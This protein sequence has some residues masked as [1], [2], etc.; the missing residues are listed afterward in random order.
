M[1]KQRKILIVDDDTTL[2]GALAENFKMKGADVYVANEAKTGLQ[3]M[4]KE[5]PDVAIVDIMMPFESG[6]DFVGDIRHLPALEKTFC[7]ILT[8]SLNAEH[9]AEAMDKNVPVFLQ[10]SSVDP[11][12]IWK[13]IEDHFKERGE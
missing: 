13:I 10:K 7:I 2:C 6:L 12:S 1:L 8:N 9:V 11:S 3:I 5:K 4:L